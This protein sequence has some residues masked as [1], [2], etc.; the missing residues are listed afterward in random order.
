M[1]RKKR[2]PDED[3]PKPSVP[4]KAKPKPKP[5][6]PKNSSSLGF[7]S[8]DPNREVEAVLKQLMGASMP[9][10]GNTPRERAEQLLQ[11][12][13]E[14][15]D[16]DEIQVLVRKALEIWPD[17][18]D[19][20]SLLAEEAK[21]PRETLHYYTEAVAAGK[22]DIGPKLFREL[23]GHFWSALETRPFMRAMNG[24]AN[25]LWLLGRREEAVDHYTAMLQLNPGDNQ[26]IRYIL[27]SCLLELGRDAE[28]AALLKQFDEDSACW[29]YSDTLLAFRREGDSPH[30]QEL[31]RV[32]QVMN[33][34]IPD[35]LVG[36]V[37]IPRRMPPYI[38]RG[39]M[40]EAVDYSA[41]NMRAWRASHGALDWLR[42]RT[43]KEGGRPSRGKPTKSPTKAKGPTPTVKKRLTRLPQ[44]ADAVWQAEYRQLPIWMNVDSE[45]VRPWFIMVISRTD[46]LILAQDIVEQEPTSA[47]LWDKLVKAMEKP[48]MG[49]PQRPSEIQVRASELWD[50]LEPD[51]DDVQ[52]QRT[53][54][55]ELD[56]MN[57][58]VASL[59]THVCGRPPAP[60]LLEM[61]GV[62]KRQVAD[63][64]HAAADFYRAAPW[65][66]VAS[67]ET[68][69]IACDTFESGPWYAAVIGQLGVTPGFALYEDLNALLKMREGDGSDEQNARDTVA[70]SVTF[71]DKTETPIPDLDAALTHAWEVAAPEGYPSAM[72]KE[73][74]LVMR[75]PLGWELQLLEA[76]LR[77]LPRFVRSHDRDDTTPAT[78]EVVMGSGTL[79]LR[80]SWI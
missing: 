42:R 6:A 80:I 36:R 38:E 19:A 79:T 31:L 15:D 11:E 27:A 72:R 69:K 53:V 50:E 70:L 26:G 74:G 51:L 12:A 35:L 22:R 20:Y 24:L 14:A 13:F 60:G 76:C 45:P 18:A 49:I 40:S 3:P 29:L 62:T 63:F 25:S 75:P 57:E 47:M 7:G 71:G 5:K 61:P 68:I 33:P 8:R 41:G 48:A 54:P 77:A 1:A 67:E 44:A 21:G 23:T 73:R 17:C 66:R 2:N 58:I 46:E 4:K 16:R 39:H 37:V 52:I 28:V 55:G 10:L 30:A 9:G 59:I 34:H 65:Q 64:F 78:E 32:A 56:L 43:A